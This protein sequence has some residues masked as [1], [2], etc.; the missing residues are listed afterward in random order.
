MSYTPTDWKAG[1]VISSQKL[2]KLEQGVA[3]AGGGGVL[4]VTITWDADEHAVLNKTWQEI[5]DA[6]PSVLFMDA[7]EEDR[8]VYMLYEQY[9]D[10]GAYYVDMGAGTRV[11][12]FLAS[13]ANDYPEYG[14]K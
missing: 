3:D 9:I 13:S 8:T 10:T 12:T 14:G 11:T 4:T 1:D 6:A 5:W 2:N 7:Q